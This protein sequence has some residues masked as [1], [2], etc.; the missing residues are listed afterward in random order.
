M[1]EEKRSGILGDTY[2]K[3]KNGDIVIRSG[4][5]LLLAWILFAILCA[6]YIYIFHIYKSDTAV[7]G[8]DNTVEMKVPEDANYR[9]CDIEEI[10]ELIVRYLSARVTCNQSALQS[11][12]TEPS[13][14]DNMDSVERVAMYLR[15]FNNTT[16]YIA[17]GYEEGSYVVIEL[18]NINIANVESEPLDILSF[19]VITDTDGSYRIYN[20]ELTAEQQAYVENLK[21]SRDIQDIYIHVKEN[22]D[23]LLETDETFA[24]FY[25]LIN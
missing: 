15:G 12:V 20:G 9:L 10:N 21:A 7:P 17:D 2:I 22:V 18:S 19:Y 3:T 25:N 1:P 11:L 24:E 13:E 16:C 4:F 23:Y 5:K 6:A 8:R 14:F